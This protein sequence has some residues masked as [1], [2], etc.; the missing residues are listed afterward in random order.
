MI[1]IV[2]MTLP[3]ANSRSHRL[4]RRNQLFLHRVAYRV[5]QPADGVLNLADG[6]V[7]LAVALQLGVPNGLANSLLRGAF[8]FLDRTGD[9]V[10]VHDW[11]SLRLRR[12]TSA[13][14]VA[15]LTSDIE[16]LD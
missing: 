15:P 9:S 16:S 12:R 5:V 7:G 11:L 4:R 1:R 3:L 6:L 10:L 14:E 8:D 2:L 13:I